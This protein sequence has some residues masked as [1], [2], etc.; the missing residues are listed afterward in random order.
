MIVQTDS[1]R[2]LGVYIDSR[3]TWKTHIAYVSSKLRRVSYL[4][5]KASGNLDSKSLKVLYYSL[6]YPHLDYCCEVWVNTYQS[7]IQCLYLLQKK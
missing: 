6:F 1:V 7:A 5:Y 3:L 2:F 4:L